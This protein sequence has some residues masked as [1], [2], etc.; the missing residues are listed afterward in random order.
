MT[1][2]ELRRAEAQLYPPTR[3]VI[4]E[5]ES[6]L[7]RSMAEYLCLQGFET[8]EASDGRA[9]HD[10]LAREVVDLVLLDLRLPGEDGLSILRDMRQN[11]MLPVIMVT[12]MGDPVDRVVGLEIG[13]DDYVTKP[14]EFRELLARIRAVLRRA[15]QDG[16]CAPA[17]NQP[18]A[19]TR[20]VRVGRVMFDRDALTLI[21]DDGAT[22]VLTKMEFDLLSVLVDRPNRVLTR[23][24][25]LDLAHDDAWTPF[26]RSIDIR[27]ARLRKK[28]E[29]D[30][31]RPT[32]I[33]TARG[34]GYM[35][36]P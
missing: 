31:S 16:A 19:V 11:S 10:L 32:T 28:I 9:L 17:L 13:A 18:A 6:A 27:I 35:F 22:T 5:D 34:A 26:D 3:I 21:E 36:V 1:P 12:A 23:D 8:L 29:V 2:E 20:A 15:A 33:R 4:V 7:R 30:P 14:F 24:Q 25:L